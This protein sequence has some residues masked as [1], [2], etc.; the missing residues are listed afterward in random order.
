MDGGFLYGGVGKFNL[1]LLTCLAISWAIN[2]LLLTASNKSM[3]YVC[4]PTYNYN[5]IVKNL[6]WFHHVK[7]I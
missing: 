7:I 2:Y 1:P 3:Q 5:L 4:K 6:S